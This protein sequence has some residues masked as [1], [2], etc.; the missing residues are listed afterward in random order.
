VELQMLTVIRP[1]ELRF[2]RWAEIDQGTKQWIIPGERM[3]MKRDHVVPLSEQALVILD[4]LHR[5][6]GESDWMFPAQRRFKSEVLSEAAVNMAIKRM[7]F[8][9]R[10][11]AHGFRAT[12]STWANESKIFHADA[13]ERQLAHIEQNRIRGAY[14]RAE[15]IEERTLLMQA[16]ADFTDA[17]R[18]TSKKVVPLRT[19][20]ASA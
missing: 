4:K 18:D 13:I 19:M 15:F 8:H 2:G 7:G 9:G 14:N 3:K 10:H 6:T 12:F 16:W 5:F 17:S 1:G 20:K 11:T